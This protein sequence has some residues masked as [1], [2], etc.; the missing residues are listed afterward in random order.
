MGPTGPKGAQGLVGPTGPQG[1]AG[2]TG[3]TGISDVYVSDEWVDL[4]SLDQNTY[5]PV[6]GD[7]MPIDRI[8]IFECFVFLD[9]KSVPSWSTHSSGFAVNYKIAILPNGWGVFPENKNT[10][11]LESDI[12]HWCNGTSPISF[13]EMW[14]SK[15]PVF[16]C[17]GGGRY[18]LR[19]TYKI[20]WEIKTSSYTKYEE[21]VSP[22]SSRP[23]PQYTF[24]HTTSNEYK[25]VMDD[26][27]A[28]PFSQLG[29]NTMYKD[30]ENVNEYN[31]T[32]TCK[33]YATTQALLN[34]IANHEYPFDGNT[35]AG[36]VSING[37]WFHLLYMG[38]EQYISV[39]I[40]HYSD[41]AMHYWHDSSSE[42][43]SRNLV[44]PNWSDILGKPS[45]FTP[46]GIGTISI[47]NYTR[48]KGSM[49]GTPVVIP[50]STYDSGG[51]VSLQMR[52][53]GTQWIL[54]VC[55]IING[56]KY[57]MHFIPDSGLQ[58][59]W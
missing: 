9:S 12:C 58:S 43:H 8:S 54:E 15:T 17:R 18:R 10:F 27:S 14:Q 28:Y 37:G 2:P 29:A 22:Q 46:D 5:F 24:A 57:H 42:W 59:G 48:F 38:T 40:F 1:I 49:N 7:V 53:N 6:I 4:T 32:F 44:T 50:R 21:T 34:S 20:N 3:D 13:T 51:V 41:I 16:W 52:H 19:T 56:Q 33:Y 47:D 11:I 55:S 26:G 36:V 35:A 23:N 30:I 45:T 31:R 39:M 25:T